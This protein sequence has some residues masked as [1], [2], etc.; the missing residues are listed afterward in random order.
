METTRKEKKNDV[1]VVQATTPDQLL[2]LALNKDVDIDKLEKLLAMKERWDAQQ[3]KKAFIE[4]L[5]E[6]QA[7]VPEIR[8]GKK[9]SY[10]TQTGQT[11]YNFAPLADVVRQIKDTCK[12]CGLSYRW[13]IQDTKE[14]IKVTCIIT[15][16]EGHT[17]RTTMTAAPDN[18]GGK[19][20]IQARG[21]SIEYLKRYTLIGAL[22]IST[23]DSDIDGQLPEIDMD[24]LHQQYMKLYNQLI[25]LDSK[26]TT[27]HPDNFKTERTPKLYIK[28]IGAIREK[29][30]QIIPKEA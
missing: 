8:K 20:S 1:A 2:A 3:Q 23:A 10:K 18:S 11:E 14:E 6:F 24:I 13:E 7:S 5:G 30:G 22:G 27:W 29:L 9:V 26:Y 16:V 28:A 12:A 4:A 21:S 19:N 25:Q 17:E 15:H